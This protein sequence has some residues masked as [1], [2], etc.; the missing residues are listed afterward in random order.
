[1]IKLCAFADEY[2]DNLDK[3][4]EGLKLNNI[5]YIELRTVNG[6][7][8]ADLTDK[9]AID[10]YEKLSKSNIKVWSIGSPLGKVDID[11]NFDEYKKI[12]ERVCV[13]ANIM[14]CDKVRMFSFFNAYDK[15]EKVFSYLQEMVNIGKKYNVLMCHENE[16]DVFGDSVDRV[17]EIQANV[18][19]LKYVYDPA[20]F[21]QCK[22][23][24]DYAIEKLFDSI[25]YFH[26]KD[27]IASSEQLVPAG[28]G[29]GKIEKFLSKIDKNNDVVLTLEPHLAEFQAYKKIDTTVMKHKFNFNSHEEAFNFAAKS[30]KEILLKIGYKEKDNCFIK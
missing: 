1:M 4:I 17:L 6:T 9:Q 30:L 11:C 2:N 21:V 20:N 18:K 7:N 3:Q 19:G 24:S 15:K 25:T 23:D 16:K 29:D 5:D 10:T 22:Q 26:I 13:I 12:I 14:H 8:V 28:Y 27:V